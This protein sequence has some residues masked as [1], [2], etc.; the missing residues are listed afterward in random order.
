MSNIPLAR[1]GMWAVLAIE[2]ICCL[3]GVKHVPFWLVCIA[4]GTTY[5][6]GLWVEQAARRS[7][8]ADSAAPR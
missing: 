7:G 3:R 2:A 5:Q 8:Q 6:F 1:W 4:T